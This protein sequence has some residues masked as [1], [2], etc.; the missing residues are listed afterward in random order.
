MTTK[1]IVGNLKMNLIT[2]SERDGYLKLLKSE[3]KN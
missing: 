3:I 2:L 1:I